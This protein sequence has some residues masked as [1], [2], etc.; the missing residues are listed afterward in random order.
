MANLQR[1][2]AV[3]SYPGRQCYSDCERTC[4]CDPPPPSIDG[5]GRPVAMPRAQGLGVN[6]CCQ[7]VVLGLF[8]L[9][10]LAAG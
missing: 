3:G 5:H 7:S 1:S 2:L 4:L 10:G 6:L 9:V 8:W